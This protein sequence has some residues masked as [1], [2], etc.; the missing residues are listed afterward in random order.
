VLK[1]RDRDLVGQLNDIRQHVK[2]GRRTEIAQFAL[3]RAKSRPDDSELIRGLLLILAEELIE[4]GDRHE[5]R[6]RPMNK[7][8]IA[9]QD[10]KTALNDFERRFRETDAVNIYHA[11]LI[12]RDVADNRE[13]TARQI[14]KLI[15]ILDDATFEGCEGR[16]LSDRFDSMAAIITDNYDEALKLA[17]GVSLP[18]LKKWKLAGVQRKDVRKRVRE[19]VAKAHQMTEEKLSDLI[20]N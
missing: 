5:G 8:N 15:W 17:Y 19:V 18:A 3:Y 13:V 16:T 11:L 9:Y 7:K 10:P 20:R 12:A 1:R 14:A 4:I 6:G 2:D